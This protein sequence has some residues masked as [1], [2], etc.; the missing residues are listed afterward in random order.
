VIFDISQTLSERIAVWPGDQKLRYRWT[1]Q[2]KKGD[3]CNVSAIQLSS[4]TGTHV[5]APYHFDEAGPD[6][7]CLP[8]RA[9]L[10][11]CR[12]AAVS[13]KDT[14]RVPDLQQHEWAGVERVLFKTCGIEKSENTFDRNYVSLSEEAALFLG[15]LGLLLIGTDAP[16]VDPFPSRDMLCHKI[17]LSKGVAIV[18]GLRLAEVPEGDYEL[19][20]LPLKLSGLDGSP[21]RAIL[22]SLPV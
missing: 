10:G 14:I 19:I 17:L 8:L 5:D 6:V 13:P 7:G 3:P 4:H 1:M 22:R 15:H 12:V 16:S 11:K 20:C 9:Y 18:E 2:I 21:V